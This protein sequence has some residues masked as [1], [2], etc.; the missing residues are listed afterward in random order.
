MDDVCHPLVPQMNQ[1][2]PQTVTVQPVVVNPV[3]VQPTLVPSY[4]Q[5]D[6][7]KQPNTV[8]SL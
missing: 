2:Q 4:V 5:F 8:P 3:T 7:V 1:I 6:E